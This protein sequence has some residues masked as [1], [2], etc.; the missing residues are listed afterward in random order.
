MSRR[1]LVAASCC[2]ALGIA[3]PAAADG[4]PQGISSD[5]YGISSPDG[6]LRYLALS[7][8]S[9]TM[10]EAVNTRDGSLATY[11]QLRGQFAIPAIAWT[12]TGLSADGKTLVVTTD[13]WL[14]DPTFVVFRAP[15]LEKKRVVRRIGNWS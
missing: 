6:K 13:P 1:L 3:V 10:V 11:A 9:Q 5:G 14:P 12:A 7:S 2:V 8:V 4:P 15:Y